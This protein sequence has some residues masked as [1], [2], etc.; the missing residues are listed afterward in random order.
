[1][2]C[3]GNWALSKSLALVASIFW[4]W[5][6]V[7]NLAFILIGYWWILYHSS[8]AM[9]FWPSML[10]R[11]PQR[12]LTLLTCCFECRGLREMST[13]WFRFVARPVSKSQNGSS[14]PTM[15]VDVLVCRGHKST[16]L[17]Y[18]VMKF[19]IKS[20]SLRVN[21]SVWKHVEAILDD[22]PFKLT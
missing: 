22:I 11:F 9:D 16:C 17:M 14:W 12:L 7:V 18:Y 6:N 2:G 4:G 3:T 20:P 5:L 21:Q 13:P 10:E 15:L 8:W 1:M 19:F